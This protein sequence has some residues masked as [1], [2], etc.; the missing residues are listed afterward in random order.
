M[1]GAVPLELFMRTKDHRYLK[2]GLAGGYGASAPSI[3]F[4]AALVPSE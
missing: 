3:A 4:F 2:L 1:F